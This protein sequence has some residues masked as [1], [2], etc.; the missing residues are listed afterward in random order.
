MMLKSS[1]NSPFALIASLT[2]L[3]E[4][5]LAGDQRARRDMRHDS[6]AEDDEDVKKVK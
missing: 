5:R 2:C 6:D 1:H 3:C 4:F